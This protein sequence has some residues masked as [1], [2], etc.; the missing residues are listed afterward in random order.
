M[1]LPHA[2]PGAVIDARPL[3]ER[4]PATPTHAL[5]KTASLELMRVVLRAGRALPPHR[6]A[7]EITVLCIE[8]RAWLR[9][10]SGDHLLS[11]GDLVLLRG[12]DRHAVEAVEDSSLLVTVLLAQPGGA[13][14]VG[15]TAAR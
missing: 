15:A 14:A 5:L 13:S 9:A 11:A 6:V 8:G 7:G 1:A 4:L 2:E 10:Q 12:G 3:G